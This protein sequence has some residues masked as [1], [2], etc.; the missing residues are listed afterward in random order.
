[1]LTADGDDPVGNKDESQKMSAAYSRDCESEPFDAENDQGNR[2]SFL[3]PLHG[4]Q[5]VIDPSERSR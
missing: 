1:M 5:T 3:R 4:A 2:I